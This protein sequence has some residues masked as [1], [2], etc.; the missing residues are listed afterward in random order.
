MLK[1]VELLNQWIVKEQLCCSNCLLNSYK[2]RGV[3]IS[4]YDAGFSNLYLYSVNLVYVFQNY[5]IRSSQVYNVAS[6]DD[7]KFSSVV[8]LFVSKNALYDK[9]LL[10]QTLIQLCQCNKGALLE[11]HY[12]FLTLTFNLSLYSFVMFS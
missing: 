10:C 6:S 8:I 1:F 7:L 2:E 5:V 11:W 12:L 4:H 3:K 9:N